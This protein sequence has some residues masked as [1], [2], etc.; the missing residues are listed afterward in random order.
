MCVCVCV[1][2]FSLAHALVCDS[3]SS[4]LP[5]YTFVGAIMHMHVGANASKCV[6]I[7]IGESIFEK[8]HCNLICG[9]ISFKTQL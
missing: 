2:S 7:R 3:I 9:V 6:G 8:S 5:R 1:C 4:S